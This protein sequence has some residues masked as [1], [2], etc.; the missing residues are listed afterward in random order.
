MCYR[1][2]LLTITTL[3]VV[4][5]EKCEYVRGPLAATND[6]VVI[7]LDCNQST[8]LSH[9]VPLQLRD[10]ATHV[11][12]QLLH[13]H[14]VPVGLFA[15]VT[16]NLTSVTVATEDAVQLLEGTFEGLGHVTE[17]RLL[18]FSLL[19]NLSRS[20]LEP[21]INIQTLIL[22]GFGSATIVLSD[23]GSAIRKLSGT[24]IRRLVL[25]KIKERLFFQQI[26][27]VDDFKI[28]N[29][30]VKELIITDAPFSYEGSIRRAFPELTCFCGGGTYA[31]T[32]VTLPAIWDLVLLSNHLEELV[33]YRSKYLPV[34]PALSVL[35]APIPFAQFVPSV[36]QKANLYPDLF[37]YFRI[38][39]G[40]PSEEC[41]LGFAVSVGTNLSKI[42][43]NGYSIA[44]KTK[45]AMCIQENNNVI[46]L[47]LSGSHMLGSSPLFIGFKRVG[48]FSIANTGVKI[49]P[50]KFLKYWP[51]LK[52]LKLSKNDIGDFIKNT[53][54]EFFGSCQ[55]LVEVHLDECNITKISTTIFSRS[56]NI[57]H[58]DVSKNRLH[59]FDIDLQNC[60]KLSVLNYSRNNIET[61]TDKSTARLNQL[62]LQKTG[63]NYLV[64]DLSYNKLRCLCNSTQ[65]IK[66]LQRLPADS[67]IKFPGF[68]SYAC[69]YPNGS[70]VLVSG[71]IVSEL[72]QQ[73]SVI[74]TLMNGSDCP[75]EEDLR[76]RL[77]QV[78]VH[79]DGFFCRNDAGDLVAMQIHP[80]PACFNPYVRASFIAPVVIGGIL[81]IAVFITI[82]LL[83]YYR[84]SRHVKEVREC[85]EMNPVHF[86]RTALQYVMMHNREEEQAL[87]QYDMI[88]FVQE[89]DR[90]SIHRHFIEALYNSRTFITGDDFQPGEPIVNA[91]EECIRV[92]RW[93]VPVLTS[94][95]L[96]NQ[97]CMDFLSRVQF[98]RP[99][100]L[101]P[102]FWEQGLDD[103]NASIAE[104]LRI[105]EPLYW[106]GN[107][108]DIE[109]KRNFWS[110]LLERT[111]PL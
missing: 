43:V 23:I 85:L 96:S 25:N 106:P 97:V 55:T 82:G 59:T 33:L 46:Y 95:F 27:Q 1:K 44:I 24:P 22:D 79:L 104:L 5:G 63:G 89:D 6:T 61:I 57:Q 19:K 11:A 45:K 14:M 47:D 110:A 48:Y 66:W 51:S 84:N 50:T 26:L 111:I 77:Q 40:L 101:I 92:C 34:V 18:G 86:V 88:I 90:S 68:N 29:V 21:L 56:V 109:T 83:I 60:T 15:N 4:V 76:R 3:S 53:D 98:S 2:L 80:L 52:V 99:H 100:A 31:Q 91:M 107:S 36:L 81:G 20:M 105:G 28:P 70:I 10:N 73:C 64:V 72:E 62:A 9:H 71:V 38:R 49:F 12:V 69:L 93:I 87:F 42:T 78:W 37:N 94:K 75:C 35:H 102:I 67:N 32:A 103:T 8:S 13:C 54:G 17:L 41:E 108:A 7:N 58:I 65:F 74:Q 16:D 30:S 39:S